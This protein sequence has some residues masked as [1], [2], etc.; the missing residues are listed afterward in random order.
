MT[1]ITM[2]D[3]RVI[4]LEASVRHIESDVSDLKDSEKEN[5]EFKRSVSESL[6]TLS[7]I[8]T[9]MVEQ[10]KEQKDDIKPRLR[11][12]EKKQWIWGGGICVASFIAPFA[13]RFIAG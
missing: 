13:I 5:Q 11:A 4:A 8:Q 12:L 2:S 7:A 3:D 10:I 1:G 6:A 9:I